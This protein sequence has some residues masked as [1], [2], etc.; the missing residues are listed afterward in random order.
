VKRQRA[1][2]S[3]SLYMSP[4]R[5]F[6]LRASMATLGAATTLLV[7]V[8]PLRAQD[9]PVSLRAAI[10]LRALSYEKTM[11]TSRAAPV[12][13]VLAPASGAAATDAAGAVV[14]FGQLAARMPIGPHKVR[15]VRVVYENPAQAI[16]AV[17][18]AGALAVYVPAGLESAL[19]ALG[20]KLLANRRI[21]MCGTSRG[22]G[23]GCVLSVEVAGSGSRPVVDVKSAEGAGLRFDAR[24]LRLARIVR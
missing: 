5:R 11:T 14:A 12:L 3:D 13:V 16:A 1:R 8:M 9:V 24:L 19:A 21:V 23:M 17:A 4:S 7:G 6:H 10:M 2:T 22:V 20:A 15:V 18:A